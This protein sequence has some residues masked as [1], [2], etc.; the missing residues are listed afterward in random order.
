[1]ALCK[2]ASSSLVYI[3]LILGLHHLT[4]HYIKY[5]HTS[6]KDKWYIMYSTLCYLRNEETCMQ[7][8]FAFLHIMLWAW[9]FLCVRYTF[10]WTAWC[11]VSVV[12]WSGFL[13]SLHSRQYLL[14]VSSTIA[15]LFGRDGTWLQILCACPWELQKLTVFFIDLYSKYF[16]WELSN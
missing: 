14:F 15:P 13:C 8:L 9:L 10:M 4:M 6:R 11:R 1:M 12:S 3:A 16:F 2:T 5:R 7:F